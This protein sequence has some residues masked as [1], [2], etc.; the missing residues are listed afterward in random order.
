MARLARA[1]GMRVEYYDIA[2]LSEDA[3]D[4]L[5]VRFRLLRELLK[6][7]DI[8]SLHVPLNDSTRHMIG[9]DELA[10]MKPEAILINTCRG[11]VI[12]EAA[13]HRALAASK[14]FGAG[15]DVFDQ[16]P[17]PPDNPL[18][19]LDNVV[20]TRAFRRAD[21]GQPR[22]PLPQR[23]RQCRA[24]PSRRGAVL[25]GAGAGGRGGGTLDSTQRAD[26]RG[27]PCFWSRRWLYPSGCCRSFSPRSCS[28]RSRH[29]GWRPSDEAET[30]DRDRAAHRT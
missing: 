25:G 18:L 28:T 30:A 6:S 22:R 27:G 5:G 24:R 8:V 2:R 19:K 10:L 7:S 15:L 17:P 21:L 29:T 26:V 4:L 20:L 1:F 11:P 12:D 9:A 16:E 3:E 14:L 23:V 13:L